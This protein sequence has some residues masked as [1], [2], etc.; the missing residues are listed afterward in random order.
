MAHRW[1]VVHAYSGFEN[2]VAQSIREQAEKK[3]LA[4]EIS[5]W[6]YQPMRVNEKRA[7]MTTELATAVKRSDAIQDQK[8]SARSKPDSVIKGS[9][10]PGAGS[11]VTGEILLPA[12]GSLLPSNTA[13]PPVTG[14]TSTSL[15][16]AI[17]SAGAAANRTMG[18]AYVVASTATMSTSRG[19]M[20][21]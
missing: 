18:P 19:D 15:Q 2:K 16:N 5:Q 6:S 11:G 4:E 9:G 14:R 12:P 1:Y 7:P 10:E 21:A 3:G 13:S 17:A 20:G 8:C